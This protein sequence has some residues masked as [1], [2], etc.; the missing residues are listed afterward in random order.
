MLIREK[1]RQCWAF[2][3]YGE[4]SGRLEGRHFCFFEPISCNYAPARRR[5]SAFCEKAREFAK[6]YGIDQNIEYR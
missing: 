2:S 5:F 4:K 6:K 3:R 1:V